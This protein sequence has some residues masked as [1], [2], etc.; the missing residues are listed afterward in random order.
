[1]HSAGEFPRHCVDV[2]FALLD[3]LVFLLL[4]FPNVFNREKC[5]LRSADLHAM[6]VSTA[7]VH[8][9]NEGMKMV[10]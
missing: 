9:V 2:V 6:H 5:S 1:M 7:L 3:R 8:L 4:P 10:D